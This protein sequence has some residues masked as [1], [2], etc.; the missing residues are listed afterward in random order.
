MSLEAIVADAEHAVPH[1]QRAPIR[2]CQLLRQLP[3]S[4]IRE[5]ASSHPDHP[6]E[7]FRRK[8]RN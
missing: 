3:L 8:T 1:L 4:L 2:D 6:P 5:P 7:Q